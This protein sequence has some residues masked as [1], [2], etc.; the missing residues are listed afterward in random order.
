MVG[1]ARLTRVC[2]AKFAKWHY[3]LLLKLPF[4]VR[5]GLIDSRFSK[6][7]KHYRLNL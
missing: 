5:P 7:I 2:G 3:M 6:D 1:I 4:A